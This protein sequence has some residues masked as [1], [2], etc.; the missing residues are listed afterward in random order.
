MKSKKRNPYKKL[1]LIY[2]VG[3]NDVDDLTRYTNKETGK[4]I[5][6]PF[7]Q[8]WINMLTRAYNKSL[9]DKEPTYRDCTVCKEWLTFSVFKDWMICQKWEGLELDK[10]IILPKNKIYSPE[11]CVFI[12][13]ELNTLL[14]SRGISRGE[15]P[16]GVSFHKASKKF[17][18]TISIN[19][20]VVHLGLFKT[21]GD[22]S[23][24]Y[25]GAKI[26]YVKTFIDNN[27]DMRIINGIGLHLGN[28]R[29]G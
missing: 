6:D 11:T 9:H 5:I 3:T 27:T 19:G 16:Q 20:K 10:D 8:T 29:E 1:K 26:T 2:G 7:Y 22:A 21:E 24:A 28:M 25:I 13:K 14:N 18:A 17:R 4:T 15:Y 12:S 23:D